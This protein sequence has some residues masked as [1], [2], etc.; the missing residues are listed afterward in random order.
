VF[1]PDVGDVAEMRLRSEQ[2][3]TTLIAV[4][5]LAKSTDDAIR[6]ECPEGIPSWA[7][8]DMSVI[9]R[10]ATISGLHVWAGEISQVMEEENCLWII[11][12]EHELIQRRRSPRVTA[13]V[14]AEVQVLDR[15]VPRQPARTVDISETGVRLRVEP[16]ADIVVS[17]QIMIGMRLP[18]GYA[19][20]L[21]DVLA[22]DAGTLRTRFTALHQSS[23]SR[24][25]EVVA[26]GLAAQ[27]CELAQSDE[28]GSLAEV[29][30]RRQAED[31]ASEEAKSETIAEMMQSW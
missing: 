17:D 2:S 21:A 24:I 31:D 28:I 11:F 19:N 5:E 20:V 29:I 1:L 22:V 26:R 6:V 14:D 27:N 16:T 9:L 30:A 18:G 10:H 12:D 25:R 3:R 23:L 15:P 13:E 8:T 4:V 7:R